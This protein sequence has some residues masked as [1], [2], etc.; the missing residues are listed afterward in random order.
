MYGKDTCYL[1]LRNMTYKYVNCTGYALFLSLTPWGQ[2][3][4]YGLDT[5]KLDYFLLGYLVGLLPVTCA[6]SIC[7]KTQWIKPF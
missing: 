7:M 2:T 4:T 6:E 5:L 1:L 3:V